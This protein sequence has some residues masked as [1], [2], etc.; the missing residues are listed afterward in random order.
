VRDANG[1]T[2]AWVYARQSEA[3]A[4][5]AKVLTRPGGWRTETPWVYTIDLIKNLVLGRN[6]RLI[7]QSF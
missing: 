6:V 1:Q 7:G 4:A 2:I 5:Q 3:E